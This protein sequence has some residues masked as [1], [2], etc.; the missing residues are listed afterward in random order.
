VG[1]ALG[2]L[3]VG[4][5]PDR[6]TALGPMPGVSLALAPLASGI[7]TWAYGRYV[8]WCGEET[9]HLAT[10]IGGA[11]LAFAAAVVRYLMVG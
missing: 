4:L 3:S 8:R 2:G 6:L 1:A 11:V 10:F 5:L 9:S 7:T